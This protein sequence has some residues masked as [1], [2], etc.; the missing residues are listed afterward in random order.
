MVSCTEFPPET[1]TT[2][3]M[4]SDRPIGPV[5]ALE[6]AMKQTPAVDF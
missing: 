4:A 2:T 6:A 5:P 3:T 1:T